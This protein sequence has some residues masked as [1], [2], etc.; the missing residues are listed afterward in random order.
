[1][2]N[3]SHILNQYFLILFMYLLTKNTIFSGVQIEIW[4]VC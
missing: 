2:Q 1:M 3:F 4:I